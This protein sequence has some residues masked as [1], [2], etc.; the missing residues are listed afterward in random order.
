MPNIEDINHKRVRLL[1][2]NEN[3]LKTDCVDGSILKE[4]RE[5]LLF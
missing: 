4:I 1:T 5:S 2:L 3:H